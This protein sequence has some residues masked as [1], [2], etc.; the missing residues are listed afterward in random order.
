MS[1]PIIERR[2]GQN[3]A[4]A[5]A[6]ILAEWERLRPAVEEV[7]LLLRRAQDILS[8]ALWVPFVPPGSVEEESPS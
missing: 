2:N 8:E 5:L 3:S 1:E 6:S 4:Q 7:Q